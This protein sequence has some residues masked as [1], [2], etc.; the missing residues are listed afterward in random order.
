MPGRPDFPK[1]AT[2]EPSFRSIDRLQEY[3]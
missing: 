1:I 3:S 2:I